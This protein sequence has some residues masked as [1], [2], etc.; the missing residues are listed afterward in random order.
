MPLDK[1]AEMIPA[2]LGVGALMAVSVSQIVW[3]LRE[4]KMLDPSSHMRFTIFTREEAPIWFRLVFGLHVV[5]AAT[6][7]FALIGF[8]WVAVTGRTL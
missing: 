6:F 4:G 7:G 5:L 1:I 8:A 3:A 2:L